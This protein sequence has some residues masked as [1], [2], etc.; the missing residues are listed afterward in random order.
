MCSVLYTAAKYSI[1]S[2]QKKNK[3]K[4]VYHDKTQHVNFQNQPLY[5]AIK[6]HLNNSSTVK[7][8]M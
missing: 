5:E 1:L 4:N 3:K 2:T 8:K 6:Q 7:N